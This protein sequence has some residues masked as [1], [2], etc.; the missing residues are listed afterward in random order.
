MTGKILGF[1]ATTNIGSISGDN[2][3][4]YSFSKE[5]WKEVSLPV[6]DQT[7]D[8]TVNNE[9]KAIEIYTIRDHNVENTNTLFGLI[10]IGITFFFGFIG[11][12]V[13]RTVLAKQSFGKALIPTLI[14]FVIMLLLFI[15]IL[16]LIIYIIGTAYFMY[17]NYLLATNK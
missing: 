6:K 1:D 15:P 12:L 2:G 8:F 7:I 9:D 14:H 3:Q 13:S 16:G 10:A 5:D 17:K 11:T 4:R